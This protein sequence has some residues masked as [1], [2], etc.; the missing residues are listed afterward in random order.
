METVTLDRQALPILHISDAVVIGGSLAG[1]AAALTLARAGR[2]VALVESRTYLGREITATLRPWIP[3][4]AA[5]D[6]S[7]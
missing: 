5:A 2:R 1:V 7:A 3:L 6:P 4:P